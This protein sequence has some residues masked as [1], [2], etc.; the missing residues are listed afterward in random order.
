MAYYRDVVNYGENQFT[1]A[2]K[3]WSQFAFRP[4][5]PK[6]SFDKLVYAQIL[7]AC[8]GVDLQRCTYCTQ[9]LHNTKFGTACS[10]ACAYFLCGACHGKMEP[11]PLAECPDDV[12]DET[13]RCAKAGVLYN[14]YEQLDSKEMYEIL[15]AKAP[16]TGRQGCGLWLGLCNAQRRCKPGCGRGC[17]AD[18]GNCGRIRCRRCV[19]NTNRFLMA[20]SLYKDYG[21]SPPWASIKNLCCRIEKEIGRP[22]KR[23]HMIRCPTCISDAWRCPAC[24][25][26]GGWCEDCVDPNR[27]HSGA[28]RRRIN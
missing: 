15:L 21:Q 19:E 22:I 14:L 20:K 26:T 24:V 17:G 9:P 2:K 11:V 13:L 28:K 7:W 18:L 12:Q 4:F 6:K 1:L 23:V 10:E 25:R 16:K 27:I 8:A 5:P 3:A